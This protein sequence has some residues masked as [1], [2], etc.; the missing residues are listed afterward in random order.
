MSGRADLDGAF[1]G[2]R[3]LVTGNMGFKGSWLSAWLESLGADVVGYC[4]RIP[5]EPSLFAEAGLA[6]RMKT[7]I[8]STVDRD[9]VARTVQDV[10]PE[11]VF[12][13]A[14]QPLV[15]ESYRE[16]YATIESNVLGTASVLD[17]LRT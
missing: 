8:G 14:A 17:A 2:R 6:D 3:V 9:K 7:V 5:T 11:I 13:L 4:D 1:G 16:P 15:L 12:H 10:Q